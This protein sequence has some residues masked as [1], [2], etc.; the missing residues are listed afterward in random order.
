MLQDGETGTGS[1]TSVTREGDTIRRPT[2]RWTPAVHALLHHLERS[3]LEGVPRVL[4]I[5]DRGREI[6]S[7]IEGDP[8]FRPW[9]TVMHGPGGLK[10]LADFLARYHGAVGSFVPGADAEW[11]VPDLNWVPGNT[12]CHGDL[13]PWNTVWRGTEL[14]GVIDWD[15][16]YPGDP[17]E[18]VAHMVWQG[19]PLRPALWKR[20]GFTN[21][22]DV[23]HRLLVFTEAYGTTPRQ[24]LDA[25]LELQDN[26]SKRIRMLGLRGIEPWRQF[27]ERGD[28]EEA[29]S[30]S[31]WLRG[32]YGRL[33]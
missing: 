26:W 25:V 14:S 1:V 8:A 31:A 13:G 17:M 6:L 3:G 22:P 23:R 30:E 29:E 2:R 19:I 20:A 9:P 10:Q 24:T 4:G 18:D 21:P 15:L 5:D 33:A 28:A 27:L 32:E 16:A 11:C 7:F 12:I